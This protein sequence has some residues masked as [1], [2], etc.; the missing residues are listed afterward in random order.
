MILPRDFN[1]VCYLSAEFAI[2]SGLPTYAGGLGVLAGDYMNECAMDHFQIVGIG[3][4]Y[5]GKHFVQHINLEGKE[6]KRDSE[7]DHDTSFLRPTT[8]KGEPVHINIPTPDGKEVIAKAYHVRLSDEAIQFFLSTDV[9][10]NPEEWIADMDTLYAGT[11]DS[12]IRQMLLLGIGGVKLTGKLAIKPRIYHFNEGRPIFAIWEIARKLMQDEK[13]D[14]DDAWDTAKKGIVYTNHTLVEAGNPK[15]DIN[16]VEWW[17][18]PFATQLQS[19][20]QTL[21]KPGIVDN[22]FS[23]TDFALN[24][25]EKHNAVS[26]VH[27]KYSRKRYP[28]HKWETITNGV[29]MYRWQDSEFRYYDMD[30]RGLWEQHMKKKREL[31]NSVLARTGFTYEPNRLVISWARRLAEYKQPTAIF[32]DVAKLK[33]LIERNGQQVQILVAGNSHANDPGSKQLIDDLIHLFATELKGHAIFIPDYNIT[34]ANHMTSGSDVWLNTPKGDMEACG[35]SGMKAIANGVLNCTVLDGWTYE[36]KWDG[37]GWVL[38]PDTVAEDFYRAL[39]QKILP[40][41]FTRNEDGL[42]TDWIDMMRKSIRLAEKYSTER[43][44]MEYQKKLY[45]NEI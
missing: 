4:L 9:D 17:T 3:I 13:L 34:L 1:P 37:I 15:Y 8:I 41:F 44:L 40:R 43:M 35:T 32:K 21:M 26:K 16:T 27:C 5:K 45:V 28:N 25:S 18:R 19:D 33:S 24:I 2:D 12:Q 36:V 20:T 10:T 22:K 38:G 7:F 11:P 30:D 29:N 14:F 23:I 39:E 42:P 31:A 6:E